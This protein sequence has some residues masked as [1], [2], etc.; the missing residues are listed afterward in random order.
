[1][2]IM[3]LPRYIIYPLKMIMM[4]YATQTSL[5]SIGQN[6]AYSN[7]ACQKKIKVWIMFTDQPH[8]LVHRQMKSMTLIAAPI[9]CGKLHPVVH[10]DVVWPIKPTQTLSQAKQTPSSQRH[11][12]DRSFSDTVGVTEPDLDPGDF[13]AKE[14]SSL[15]LAQTSTWMPGS[16]LSLEDRC[17]SFKLSE[18]LVM[19]LISVCVSQDLQEH[20][21]LRK[22]RYCGCCKI[23]H[24]SHRGTCLPIRHQGI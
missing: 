21:K 4:K 23:S 18:V 14:E 3:L 19:W 22:D 5:I 16:S 2:A 24:T 11:S 10:V 8:H 12:M 9:Q 6:V 13:E 15:S 1:M 7:K 20:K 17:Y